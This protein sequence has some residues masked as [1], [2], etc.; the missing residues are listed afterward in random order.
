MKP[1]RVLY[2]GGN[3][4]AIITKFFLPD[5]QKKVAKKIM[6]LHTEI[7]QVGFLSSSDNQTY[8]CS[9]EMMGGEFCLNATRCAAFIWSQ[10]SHS[11][12]V[13][14]KISGLDDIL[15][16]KVLK[17]TVR[18]FFPERL[19]L[20]VT[21]IKE[22]SIVDFPG[23]KLLITDKDLNKQHFK[24]LLERY[25]SDSPAFG[26]IKT[27]QFS[28]NFISIKPLIWVRAV[29]SLVEET[30]CGS[31]S[32]AACFVLYK[33]FDR[34][35]NFLVLQ[36]SGDYYKVSFKHSKKENFFTLESSIIEKEFILDLYV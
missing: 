11:N 9:L 8:D 10:Y 25:G 19:F 24:Y 16:V 12:N 5:L 29:D 22:G 31:G 13:L 30:G 35:K 26:L 27:A 34:I 21:K 1:Y 2:P 7:E 17:N 32:L 28:E 23:I 18:I 15:R 36:P 20:N 33:K 4:T 3:L 14:L 6:T